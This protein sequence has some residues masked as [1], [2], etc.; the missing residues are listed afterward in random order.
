MRFK[1]AHAPGE[2]AAKAETN[3]IKKDEASAR[4]HA[5]GHCLVKAIEGNLGM[6]NFLKMGGES[7]ETEEFAAYSNPAYMKTVV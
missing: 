1:C 7:L 2:A 3:E 6:G 5:H 4:S